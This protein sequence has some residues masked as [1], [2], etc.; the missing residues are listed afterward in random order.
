MIISRVFIIILLGPGKSALFHCPGPACLSRLREFVALER[1]NMAEIKSTLDLVMER[2]RGLSMTD[3]EKK[4]MKDRELSGKIQ[5]LLER[6]SKDYMGLKWLETE[7]HNM[8]MASDR[9]MREVLRNQLLEKL[10]LNGDSDKLLEALEGILG[11]RADNYRE[12]ITKHKK[13][14]AKEKESFSKKLRA[15]LNNEKIS[16]SAVLPNIAA[17]PGWKAELEKMSEEFR[18][19]LKSVVS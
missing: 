2:T 8:G 15:E 18:N 3:R 4:E 17:N 16:G 12:I 10:S 5:A 9:D 14:L 19:K 6:Y 7:L 1:G 11:V 13:A